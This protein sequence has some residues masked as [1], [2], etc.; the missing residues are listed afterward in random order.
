MESFYQ[1]RLFDVVIVGGGISGLGAAIECASRGLET[2][3][4]EKERICEETSANSLRIIHGGFR[5]LQSLD[6]SRILESIEDQGRILKEAPSLVKLLPCVLPLDKWGLRSRLPCEVATRIFNAVR[7]LKGFTTQHS[8]VLSDQFVEK[9]IPLFANQAK[10]GALLWYDARIRDPQKFAYLMRHKIDR[11]GGHILENSKVEKII[12]TSK[13]FLLNGVDR[14]GEFQL[15]TRAIINASGKS[16]GELCPALSTKI[17][18]KWSRAFNVILRRK[19]DERFAIASKSSSGRFYFVVPRGAVSVVGTGY[20]PAEMRDTSISAAVGLSEAAPFLEDFGRT[21]PNANFTMQ[22]VNYIESGLVP[23]RSVANDG[24]AVSMFG[25]SEILAEEG[26]ISILATKYTSFH[27][28]GYKA[29]KM[30][31]KYL[32]SGS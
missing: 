8:C 28:I 14:D 4:L 11:E 9:H 5:Y 26:I 7:A 6:F 13:V 16:V 12:K 23:V 18:F 22:D 2:L 19:L 32:K 10:D 31:D 20:L 30:A 25:K 17:P 29:Y 24:I 1:N 3:V 15:S 21:F 27:S